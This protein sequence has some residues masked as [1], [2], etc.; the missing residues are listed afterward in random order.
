MHLCVPSWPPYPSCSPHLTSTWPAPPPLSTL[1]GLSAPFLA[2][3]VVAQRFT[4]WV[5]KSL[6][7]VL[8]EVSDLFKAIWSRKICQQCWQHLIWFGNKI[9]VCPSNR[10]NWLYGIANIYFHLKFSSS[11]TF[12]KFL[13]WFHTNMKKTERSTSCQGMSHVVRVMW[14]STADQTLPADVRRFQRQ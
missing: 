3:A 13:N 8:L 14:N 1:A 10:E 5:G 12:E 9:L 7:S 11:L 2:R 6:Q 4:R